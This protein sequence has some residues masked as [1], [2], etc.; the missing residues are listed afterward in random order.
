MFTWIASPLHT[1]ME[2]SLCDFLCSKLSLPREFR[3]SEGGAGVIVGTR[4]EALVP[5]LYTAKHRKQKTL[6]NDFIYGDQQNVGSTELS[7]YEGRYTVYSYKSQDESENHD[8]R[9]LQRLCMFQD[10][11]CRSFKLK[12]RDDYDVSE[13]R[14]LIEK[15]KAEGLI[16][17]VV[18][19]PTLLNENTHKS[20]IAEMAAIAEEQQMWLHI[21]LSTD[22]CFAF[23]NRYKFLTRIEGADSASL[24]G[25]LHLRCGQ[26]LHLMW[27]KDR[28][29]MITGLQF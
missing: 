2:V 28:D 21:D 25:R 15:D 6:F 12:D 19:A 9:M 23:L 27:T 13:L 22:G 3:Y 10:L 26:D 20:R 11:Q 1:E 8:F 29:V 18:I 16:P 24:D 14:S 17:I 4:N 5:V 7:C